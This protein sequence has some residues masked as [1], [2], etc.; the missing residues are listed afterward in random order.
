M[1]VCLCVWNSI[2]P[3]QRLSVNLLLFW[4][5]PDRQT[6]LLS[7]FQPVSLPL[8]DLELVLPLRLLRWPWPPH[9]TPPPSPC[10]PLTPHQW[11]PNSK[12][13]QK[14]DLRSAGAGK[15]ISE[16]IKMQNKLVC[17]C[18]LVHT[19]PVNLVLSVQCHKCACWTWC[20]CMW[21]MPHHLSY[22]S[23]VILLSWKR[24]FVPAINS[25]SIVG[26]EDKCIN[27]SFPH[28]LLSKNSFM[29]RQRYTEI[30]DA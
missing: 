15:C 1:C 13:K 21:I 5:P 3:I 2:P 24:K 27:P 18:L 7:G 29:F 6:I 22:I 14:Y 8:P 30:S 11:E 12:N 4:N 19:Y 9:T 17:C 23:F 26:S 16:M 25:E 20:L 10:W 28:S